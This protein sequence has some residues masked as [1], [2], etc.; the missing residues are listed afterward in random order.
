MTQAYLMP[1]V[2]LIFCPLLAHLAFEVGLFFAHFLAQVVWPIVARFRSF[3][4]SNPSP[5]I[6][7]GRLHLLQFSSHRCQPPMSLAEPML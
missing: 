2:G 3:V 5:A 4:V 7:A 6:V 1:I